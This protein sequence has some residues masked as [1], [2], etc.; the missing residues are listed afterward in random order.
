MGDDFLYSFY[1]VIGD[2]DKLWKFIF[3]NQYLEERVS[4]LSP[5]IHFHSFNIEFILIRINY[6]YLYE[7]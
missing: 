2:L 1:R 4:L 7:V 5:Y 6:Y 3:I